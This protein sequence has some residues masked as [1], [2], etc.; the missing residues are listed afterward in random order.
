MREQTQIANEMNLTAAELQQEYGKALA[1]IATQTQ[2]LSEVEAERD[3]DGWYQGWKVA[4]R[5][6]DAA[7]RELS[8]LRT[9]QTR[10]W[11]A[12]KAASKELWATYSDT[13]RLH[14]LFVQID[15]ALDGVA[16]SSTP[17]P[18]TTP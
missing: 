4:V 13:P 7:E 17:T 1:M 14:P 3:N 5:Q 2:R 11:E 18:E 10:L 9:E 12:L 6:R 15:A 16:L 8:T